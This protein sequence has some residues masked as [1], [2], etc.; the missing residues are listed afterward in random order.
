MPL[1]AAAR[2]W[3]RVGEQRARHEGTAGD[4]LHTLAPKPLIHF[5]SH[6]AFAL[7]K[8]APSSAQDTFAQGGPYR[9]SFC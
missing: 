4:P 6:A 9:R 5:D 7:S 2:L 3:L 8:Y 1:H